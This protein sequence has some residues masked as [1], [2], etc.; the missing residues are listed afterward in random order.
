MRKDFQHISRSQFVF[1][2]GPSSIIETKNGP[3]LIPSLHRGL[4]RFF[5][6]DVFEKF[7]IPDIRLCKYIQKN[8][9][10][11]H[12]VRIVALPSNA[13]LE[14]PDNFRVYAT[15][16]FP[17]WSICYGR[18]K[19][20][21]HEPILYVDNVCPIC[22][23]KEDSGV[24]RFVAACSA[25]HLDEVDWHYAVHQ[26]R[27]CKPQFYYWK[28]GGSSLADIVIQCP[29][30]KEKN[31]MKEIYR[32]NFFCT[33]RRPE[34]EQPKGNFS[35]YY[36]EIKRP[37]NCDKDMK[38]TQR[39]STS[40]RIADTITLLT[41]PKYDNN[42]TRVL[43]R[44]AISNFLD[45]MINLPKET[46]LGMGQ[47]GLIKWMRDTLSDKV[48][49][50]AVDTIISSMESMGFEGFFTFYNQLNVED[51]SF[52]GMMYEEFESLRSGA[53]THKDNF[54][55]DNYEEYRP[56]SFSIVPPLKIFPVKKIRTITVQ[57]GY[58]RMV[59]GRGDEEAQSLSTAVLLGNYFWYP[60][61]EGFGEGI[62]ITPASGKI[63]DLSSRDAYSRWKEYGLSGYA[64]NSDWTE[65]CVLPE[66]IWLH[67]L[68]HALIRALAGFTGYSAASLRE[69]IYLS[70]DGKNGGILIYNT[71]P[72]EDGG[73]GG[74]TGNVK[75]FGQ[76]VKDAERIIDV[77]SNDPLCS[78]LKKSRDSINGAACYSCLLLSETSCEHRNLWLDRHLLMR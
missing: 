29:D 66:F 34:N 11:D 4:G 10:A 43:Q 32:M 35:P 3:R 30:C 19:S 48:S 42:L 73:M 76:I 52:L 55:M 49:N 15:Q 22:K 12:K 63:P 69:R 71:S 45:G 53:G 50:D 8:S 5:S 31:T 23:T 39:Q 41:I 37:R 33:G 77:C 72:G 67:T 54:I 6:E 44:N 60:G 57:T 18:R 62:F 7:E 58:R 13:G 51:T 28:V 46:L 14:K 74:L 17:V 24:V 40:L 36:S 59:S 2:Y 27:G 61:F 64:G 75:S 1:T 47:E 16:I 20:K 65:I 38:I 25:G 9:K 78:D 68:S 26:H 56:E 21:K 70:S